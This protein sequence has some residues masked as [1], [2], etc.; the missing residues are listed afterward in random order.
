M[1]SLHKLILISVRASSNESSSENAENDMNGK[2][3]RAMTVLIR[4]IG[5][6]GLVGTAR[7]MLYLLIIA[8]R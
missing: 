5:M 4:N 7:N 2:L 3:P 6:G 1:Q 8:F